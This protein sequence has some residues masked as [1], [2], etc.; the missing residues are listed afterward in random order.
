MCYVLTE[1]LSVWVEN[2]LAERKK[3]SMS[4]P[5]S[6]LNV[7]IT[8]IDPK[9]SS[10]GCSDTICGIYGFQ[11]KLF[12]DKWYIGQSISILERWKRYQSSGCPNQPKFHAALKKYGFENFNRII[13]ENCS[14]EQLDN[15]EIYWI[16]FHGGVKKGY[17]LSTGGQF[18]L[19]KRMKKKAIKIRMNR[20]RTEAE[21]RHL[22]KLHKLAHRPCL[23]ETRR[24]ISIAQIGKRCGESN[25]LYGKPRSEEVKR[26]ISRANLGRKHT[27]EAKEKMRQIALKRFILM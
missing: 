16:D 8:P 21:L 27:E 24:K 17:N 5:E 9:S 22:D 14:K 3:N 2:D 10:N 6:D 23:K 11:N 15:R 19:T 18:P 4:N 25:P 12:P 26:K 20:P 7:T 1:Y 13:I